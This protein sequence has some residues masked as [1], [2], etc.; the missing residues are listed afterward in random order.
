MYIFK[1]ILETMMD[2]ATGPQMPL[3]ESAGQSYSVLAAYIGPQLWETIFRSSQTSPE[4]LASKALLW[5]N[6]V[7][8]LQDMENHRDLCFWNS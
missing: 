4:E 2:V 7:F 5:V 8:S 3:R 6:C 1:Y